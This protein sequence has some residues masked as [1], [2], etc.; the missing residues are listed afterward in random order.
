MP[1]DVAWGY[2]NDSNPATPAIFGP[3]GGDTWSPRHTK[4][5]IETEYAGKT[6]YYAIPIAGNGSGLTYKKL[7]SA[8]DDGTAY[9]G[10]KANYSYQIEELVLTRLGST[11]PDE[12][13]VE[14]N[15]NFNITVQNWNVVLLGAEGVYEI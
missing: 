3:V 11:N 14:S 6:Y 12:P 4:L 1:N 10:I 8:E 2:D 13:T 9:A 15:V 7:G 5:V